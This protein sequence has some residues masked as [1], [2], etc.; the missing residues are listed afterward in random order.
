M[1]AIDL[2]LALPDNV[3]RDA[4]AAGLLTSRALVRLVR[5]E[6]RRQAAARLVAGAER[7]VQAGG[8]PL[9][10]AAIQREVASIRL[11]RKARNAA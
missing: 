7:A 5:D 11:A 3:A 10:M 1:T 6:M 9:S 4:Q 8:K 2:T